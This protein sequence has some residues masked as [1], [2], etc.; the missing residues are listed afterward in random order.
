MLCSKRDFAFV[1]RFYMAC[2][3]FSL[4]ILYSS[5]IF[6][7]HSFDVESHLW[8]QHCHPF[9]PPTWILIF[10]LFQGNTPF[11]SSPGWVVCRHTFIYFRPPSGNFVWICWPQCGYFLLYEHENSRCTINAMG[12]WRGGSHA[13]KWLNHYRRVAK[14]FSLTRDGIQI[15]S[16]IRDWA[17][18]CRVRRDWA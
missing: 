8:R 11:V 10:G 16:A 12:I 9:I 18:I 13:W 15:V 6:I 1:S 5:F 2:T 7:K 14:G 3:L 17:Q 4:Y